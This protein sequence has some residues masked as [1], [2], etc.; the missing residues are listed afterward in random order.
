MQYQD[1]NNL[2]KDSTK[3]CKTT[4]VVRI[5]DCCREG[6]NDCPHGVKKPLKQKQNVGL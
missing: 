4:F 5:P 3:E 6:R 1:Q 2:S